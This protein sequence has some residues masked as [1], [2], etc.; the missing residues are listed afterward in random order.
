MEIINNKIYMYRGDDEAL[1]VSIAAD[2]GSPVEMGEEETLTLTVR[3][4]PT[5]DSPVQL[6]CT[7]EPGSN[8]I[9]IPHEKTKDVEPGTYS[10]DIQLMTAAGKRHTVW[11]AIDRDNLLNASK[12]I[13]NRANFVLYPEVT[14]D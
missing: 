12:M 13:T 3:Q 14:T 2:D 8:R 1:I 7:S 5:H 9:A 4:L 10:A 11:P 6:Q